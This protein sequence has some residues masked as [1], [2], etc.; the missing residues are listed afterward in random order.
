MDLFKTMDSE[1]IKLCKINDVLDELT[2]GDDEKQIHPEYT[3]KK[4]QKSTG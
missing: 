4:R 2:V 3:T 1:Y